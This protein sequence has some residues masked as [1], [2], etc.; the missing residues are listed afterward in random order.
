MGREDIWRE[1]GNDEYVEGTLSRGIE[2]GSI[3][4]FARFG[5]RWGLQRHRREFF[6]WSPFVTPWD[7]WDS[8][9]VRSFILLVKTEQGRQKDRRV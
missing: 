8:C 7:R 1:L 4:V 2:G 5:R 3:E 9:F 6:L